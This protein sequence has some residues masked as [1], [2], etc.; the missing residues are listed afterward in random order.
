MKELPHGSGGWL[1]K[2]SREYLIKALLYGA[3][4]VFLLLISTPRLPTHI[5]PPDFDNS[6]TLF[7]IVPVVGAYLNLREYIACNRGMEGERR[8]KQ[9][10]DSEFGAG[11]YIIN[12]V[13]YVYDEKKNSK[14]NIDHIIL[15]PNGIFVIETKATAG[16]ITYKKDF[17]YPPFR[18]SPSK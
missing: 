5:I 13:E 15:G 16:D 3:A 10:L 7:A 1:K 2:K 17:W 18:L 4:F 14:A 12:D 8:V 6:V 9:H 11:Y